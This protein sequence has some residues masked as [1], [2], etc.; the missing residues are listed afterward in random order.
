MARSAAIFHPTTETFGQ[1]T[2]RASH[3]N[4]TAFPADW[5]QAWRP[6][7]LSEQDRRAVAYWLTAIA[8]L[9]ACVVAVAGL[10]VAD[11]AVFPVHQTQATPSIAGAQIDYD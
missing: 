8:F 3:S 7:S 11:R 1:L 10:Y 5:T 2:L 6:K 9:L 4:A